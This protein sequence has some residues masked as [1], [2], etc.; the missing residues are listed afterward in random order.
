MRLIGA[1]VVLDTDA[2]VALRPSGIN[3]AAALT[4]GIAQIGTPFDMRFDSS[5]ASALFCAELIGLVYPTAPLPRTAVLG[6]ET[7]VIDA[8]VAASLSG[9]LPFGLVGYV[10]ASPGGGARVQSAR[11]LALDIRLQWPDR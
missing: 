5:D 2:V 1:N 10:T 3:R 11:D 8:I 6:R 7:I 4:R 9:D